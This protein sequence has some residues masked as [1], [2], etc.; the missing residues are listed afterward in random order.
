MPRIFILDVTNRDGAQTSR[1]TL[2][3]LQKTMVNWYLSQLGIHQSELGFPFSEHEGRYVRA[4][5]ALGRQGVFGEMVLEGWSRA[6]ASDV[7]K[8]LETGVRDFNLSMSTSD[9]MITSKFRG[10]LDREAVIREAVEAVRTAVAGGARTVGINAEDGSRT[11]P[12]YLVEFAAAA[13]DAGAQRLRYCDTIGCESPLAIRDRA[14]QL[15]EATG[16][17]IEM[18]C[19]NDLGMAVANSLAGAQGVLAGGADVYINTCVN[20][21]GERAGNADLLSC[22]LGLQFGRGLPAERLADD[23]DLTVAWKLGNYVARALGQPVPLN[24]VGIGGNAF[25]HESGIHADGALKDHRNYE[26]YDYA[27]IGRPEQEVLPTGRLITV[28]D[29]SGLAA[30][31]YVYDGL[32]L[33]FDSDGHAQETLELVQYANMHNQL[34][35]TEDELRFIH[36]HPAEV[37]ELL[38]A[39]PAAGRAARV[40]SAASAH[41]HR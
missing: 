41:T 16:M 8:A 18:H 17:A 24:Q 13:R 23:L 9:Q 12:G 21:I 37:A 15:A 11:D 7:E 26:L 25:A 34:P 5:L 29:Y 1:L 35:L 31:R 32:G 28:G 36:A 39:T 27:L 40:P 20:G 33:G 22:I 38:T 4:N 6:L 10:R 2:S 3:K 19:H 14:Q 30:L